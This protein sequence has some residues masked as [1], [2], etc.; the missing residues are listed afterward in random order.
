M[1]ENGLFNI[2]QKVDRYYGGRCIQALSVCFDLLFLDPFGLLFWRSSLLACSSVAVPYWFDANFFLLAACKV[3][4][5]THHMVD[6]RKIFD[7][8]PKYF[9]VVQYL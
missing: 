7:C 2:P 1:D 5:K 4:Q 3:K 9:V 8:L 6:V